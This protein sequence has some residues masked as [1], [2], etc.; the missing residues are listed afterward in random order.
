[1]RPSV[2]PM[3]PST[4]GAAGQPQR[5]AASTNFGH[6]DCP[7]LCRSKRLLPTR[8]GSGCLASNPISDGSRQSVLT[9]AFAFRPAPG[10]SS[11][12]DGKNAPLGADAGESYATRTR[13][14][15]PRVRPTWLVTLRPLIRRGVSRRCSRRA[16]SRVLCPY[17]SRPQPLVLFVS[18]LGGS[19]G[20]S[21]AATASAS[22]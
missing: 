11:A 10:R 3:S 9:I 12:L 19:S 17:S 8:C 6:S 5:S 7:G 4:R 18:W 13:S 1:M 2:P 16:A 15:T 21:V 22:S 20:A 14:P